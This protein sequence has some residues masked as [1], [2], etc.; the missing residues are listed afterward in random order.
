[1]QEGRELKLELLRAIKIVQYEFLSGETRDVNVNTLFCGFLSL[2]SFT[3]STLYFFN[4][5]L[6]PWLVPR[7]AL[8]ASSGVIFTKWQ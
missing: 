4:N 3:I 6:S 7:Y 2:S 1:M 8:I 5:V